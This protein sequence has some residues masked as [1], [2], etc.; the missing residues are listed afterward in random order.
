MRNPKYKEVTEFS[1]SHRAVKSKSKDSIRV[2]LILKFAGLI[3]MLHSFLPCWRKEG[4]FSV[5]ERNRKSSLYMLHNTF[6]VGLRERGQ[7]CRRLVAPAHLSFV[8]PLV[9]LRTC[10]GP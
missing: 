10:D 3:T 8:F 9:N 5:G 6:G 7:N 1:G 2:C 4:G